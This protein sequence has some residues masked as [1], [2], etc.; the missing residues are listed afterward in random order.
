[1]SIPGPLPCMHYFGLSQ[2][3]LPHGICRYL[4]LYLNISSESPLALLPHVT[5][6]R[7]LQVG[8]QASMLLLWGA[9]VLAVWS[10]A[11]YFS[12]AWEHFFIDYTQGT[13]KPSP[14][15]GKKSK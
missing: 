9:A 7:A 2:P 1:M 8:V 14:T 13:P 4:A 11:I 10:F 12:N 3:V 5:V 6:G 15:S